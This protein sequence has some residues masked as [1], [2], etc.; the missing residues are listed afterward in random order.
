MIL[1]E[2]LARAALDGNA[3][4]LRSLTQDWLRENPR[5]GNVPPPNTADP[6]LRVVAAALVELMAERASQSPPTWTGRVG[7]MRQPMF[8]LKSAA[9]MRRLRQQCESE[10]PAPLRRRRLFAPA[11]YLCFA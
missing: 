2:E 8:L 6:D 3:L 1:I 7:A 11:N 9:T 5:I 4:E 10:S